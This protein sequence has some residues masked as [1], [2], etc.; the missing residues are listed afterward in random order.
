MKIIYWSLLDFVYKNN[1]SIEILMNDH[2]FSKTGQI[3][4]NQRKYQNISIYL[5][6]LNKVSYQKT[7]RKLIT[8][9]KWVSKGGTKMII[10][11]P[12]WARLSNLSG[13]G[14]LDMNYET[15]CTNWTHNIDSYVSQSYANVNDHILLISK[16]SFFPHFWAQTLKWNIFSRRHPKK[17]P[18]K[19]LDSPLFWD[20]RWILGVSLPTY[21]N[22]C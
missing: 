10:F 13:I 1:F 14:H 9:L 5:Y 8:M 2:F 4:K 12:N 11:P 15:T 3:T 17:N 18:K 19:W 21:V 7:Y 16:W 6:F 22:K 20:N